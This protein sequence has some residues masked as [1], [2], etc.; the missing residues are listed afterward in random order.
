MAGAHVRIV[1]DETMIP[2]LTALDVGPA[3]Q[4]LSDRLSRR[5]L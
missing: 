2:R 5:N 4:R 1:P 3:G